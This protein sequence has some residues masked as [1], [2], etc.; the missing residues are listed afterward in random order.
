MNKHTA[1][2]I[3]ARI[4]QGQSEFTIGAYRYFCHND[5]ADLM[6]YIMRYSA[7]SSPLNVGTIENGI[8]MPEKEPARRHF[9]SVEYGGGESL[10]NPGHAIDYMTA[11][12]DG[13]E[14]YAEMEPVDGDETGTYD[15]LKAAIIE[16]AAAAGIAVNRLRFWY[17]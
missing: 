9:I 13:V 7:N 14:L 2:A 10:N 16:Q 3:Q 1:N 8:F 5:H 17:D 6:P 15:S 4:N 12:V 11:V